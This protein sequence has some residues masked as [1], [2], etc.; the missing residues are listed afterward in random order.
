[1]PGVDGG[2]TDKSTGK[3]RMKA[4][5]RTKADSGRRYVWESR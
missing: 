3:K 5:Q 2:K 4:I 1:M